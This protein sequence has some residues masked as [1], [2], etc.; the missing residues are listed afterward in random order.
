MK[1]NNTTYI[2]SK[3]ALFILNKAFFVIGNGGKKKKLIK[4]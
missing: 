4:N 3:G 1:F 2:K